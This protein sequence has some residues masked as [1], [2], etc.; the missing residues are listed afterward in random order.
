MAKHFRVNIP[1]IPAVFN[2]ELGPE[3]RAWLKVQHPADYAYF[4]KQEKA[5]EDENAAADAEGEKEKEKEASKPAPA[6]TKTEAT[7]PATSAP[8]APTKATEGAGGKQ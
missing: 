6:T 1:N 4:V 7:K 2:D 3:H 5:F 8:T